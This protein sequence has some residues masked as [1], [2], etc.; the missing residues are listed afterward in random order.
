MT[1]ARGSRRFIVI[2]VWQVAPA[3]WSALHLKT[4]CSSISCNRQLQ[5]KIQRSQPQSTHKKS[6]LYRS[7]KELIYP[8]YICHENCPMLRSFIVWQVWSSLHSNA[9]CCSISCSRTSSSI[10]SSSNNPENSWSKKLLVG[11]KPSEFFGFRIARSSRLN[12][13]VFQCIAR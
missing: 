5:Q 9:F 8:P 12:G 7:N 2:Q 4:F 13:R 6:N 3:V 10:K 1:T 11:I